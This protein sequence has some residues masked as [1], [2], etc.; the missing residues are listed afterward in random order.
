[1]VSNSS[2]DPAFPEEKIAIEY[3]GIVSR[4]SRHT[5]IKAQIIKSLRR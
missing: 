2:F 5:T 3:E 4:K 1:M